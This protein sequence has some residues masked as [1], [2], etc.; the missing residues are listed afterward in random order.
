[1]ERGGLL[2]DK[3]GKMRKAFLLEW[4]AGPG[5]SLIPAYPSPYFETAKW[6][7]DVM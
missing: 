2:A 4:P 7:L 6:S 3:H 5:K 1:L